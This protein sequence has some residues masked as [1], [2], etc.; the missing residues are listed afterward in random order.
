[1]HPIGGHHLARRVRGVFQRVVV[2][3]QRAR[4]HGCN[5]GANGDHRVAE[6]VE[7]GLR[8][9]FRRLDHQRARHRPAH[10][11]CVIAEILQAFGDVFHRN[12]RLG[13]EA[14]AIDDAFMRHHAR[15]A[16]VE[17][18]VMRAQTF[19]DVVGV[20]NRH[21]RRLCQPRRPHH[22]DIGVGNRQD[23]RRAERGSRHRTISRRRTRIGPARMIRQMRQQMGCHPNRPHPR[24]AAA[25]RNAECLVQIQMTHIGTNRAR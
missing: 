1:M 9:A 13:L 6:A 20:Q 17:D 10:R 15:G 14:S 24:P 3:V 22:A 23:Q 19:G 12:A 21:L 11:R 2:A 5:L 25:M 4:T 18:R 16:G 7:F 8:L